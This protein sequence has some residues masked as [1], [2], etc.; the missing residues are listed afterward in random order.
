LESAFRVFQAAARRTS[1]EQSV[2]DGIGGSGVKSHTFFIHFASL[3]LY[4][5]SLFPFLL[6]SHSFF[7]VPSLI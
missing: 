4:H 1:R 7:S 2:T 5:S 3:R 6:S